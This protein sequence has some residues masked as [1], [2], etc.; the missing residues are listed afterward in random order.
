MLCRFK[1][2]LILSFALLSFIGR[3]ANAQSV[4]LPAPRLLTTM[5]M[6][7]KAG[8]QVE[9]TITG[10]HL[11][12][13]SDLRFSDPR[14]TATPKLDAAGKPVP[15]TYV[16]SIAADCPAGLYEARLM[17]RLGV[18]SSR[19]FCVGDLDE[20]VRTKPNTTL[21]T[22]MEVRVNSVC[23]AVMSVRA[24]DHYAFDARKDQRVI[25][26]CATR[27]I[28]SKLDAVVIVAD[29]AGRDLQVERRGGV[30]DFTAPADG[31][32]V[33][34][35]HELTY[36]GGPAFYYR[37]AVRELPPGAAIVRQP[38]TKAVNSFSWPPTGLPEQAATAETEPNNDRSK[39][40]RI[41]LPCDVSGSFFPAADVDFYEF[42]AKKG[43]EW[44]VEVGS[45]RLGLPT[46]PS[47]LVQRVVGSG[48]D[49][50]ATDIAE[51]SDIPSPVKVSSNGYAY[52]GP[53]YN[54][55]T[56]D[57]LG[58]LTI[59]EDGLYRLQ[60]TD[61]FGGTRNDR[62]NVYRLVI[63]KPQPEF[64]LVAWALH[65]E[66]RNG[67]RNALSKPLALRGGA[68][69]ALEVVAFRRDGFNGDIELVMEG[70]PEGVTAQGLKI[71]AGQSRGM[72]LVTASQEAPRALASA[73]F[74][75]RAV[76]NGAEMI[77][78]CRLASMAWPIPDSWGEIPYPRLL[79]DVPV[80]VSGFD[81]SPLTIAPVSSVFQAA[82]GS[83]LTIPLRLTRRSEFSGA[84]MQL[85]TAGAGGFERVPQF[86]LSLTAD[87]TQAVIDLGALKTPPG[88]YMIAFYGGAV[89]KY[90]HRPDLIAVAEEA[91]KQAE[92]QLAEIDAEVKKTA[93][94][95]K[96]A[97]EEKKAE[98]AKAVEAVTA[99]QKAAAAALA[100]AAEQVK[101]ATQT[102]QP[103]DIVD[104][105][106]SEPIAIRVQ[107]AESK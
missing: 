9:I 54:A 68:T 74:F 107:P 62:R 92:R 97:S 89:A 46:D 102:A 90:R 3:A 91:R 26:D 87:E 30:L 88:D 75:G 18:S 40:Q 70:L 24:V 67:D 35:V 38:S 63:R 52:D 53:P 28:D 82:A 11:D 103:T 14:L 7:G 64:A 80:S 37:L 10:E 100:A 45:E 49:E 71:P 76:V 61:L 43:E 13:A 106:V 44:W 48:A 98:A 58:K 69:M 95:A 16:V 47:I 84:T 17:T 22:A 34:K 60:I 93:D 1:F 99:R 96:A 65:M 20:L 101:K 55:G 50:K 39:A 77:R 23:N 73:R 78:P 12:D 56:A 5:P 15:N 66:L 32:Y 79:A 8:T 105:V 25:I 33:I 19:V 51:F 36:K 57:I 85:R 59:P 86:N 6:G 29:A 42:E 104:I 4:C 41:T 31:R 81:L 94:E 2:L 21:A 27:G 72:V 83:K